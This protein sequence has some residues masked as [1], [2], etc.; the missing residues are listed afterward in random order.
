MSE[1][2]WSAVELERARQ[3]WAE[4]QKQHDVSDRVGQTA[5]IDPVSGRVWFGESALDIWQ[6]KQ[7]EGTDAPCYYVRV[8]KDYYLR[9]GRSRFMILFDD[10]GQRAPD[11]SGKETGSPP[12]RVANAG[13]IESA[14]YGRK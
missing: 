13:R 7:A 1:T 9:K 12:A 2:T 5:G 6:Q 14:E 11:Q 3:I 8:G 10:R 4:Y